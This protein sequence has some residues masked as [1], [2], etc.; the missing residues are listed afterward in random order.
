LTSEAPPTEALLAPRQ[1][2]SLAVESAEEIEAR[3]STL[4]ARPGCYIFRDKNGE[5]LYVGKAK[6]LRSRVRSYFQSSSS[7]DRAFL[8]FLRGYA[9]EL[10]TIV[11]DTEKEAAILE[12]SLIKEQHPR[13]NVKLRDD[14]E[15]LTLRLDQRQTWPRLDLVRRPEPDGARYYGPYHSATAARRTLKLVEKHFQLRTCSDRE[16]DTRT[17]PCLQYQIKRC[18]GPCVYEVDRD[19]YG[20]QVRSVGLFLEGRHDELT[21]QLGARMQEAS[22]DLRFELAAIYRDQM[23]AIESVRQHQRVVAVTDK[24]QDVV[25]IYR[26]GDLIEISVLYVR[27]G[28][29]I[30]AVSFSP[31]RVE[32]PDQEVVAGYIREHYSDDGVGAA[33]PDEIILPLLPEGVE[34]ISEWLS[35]AGMT[36]RTRGKANEGHERVSLRKVQLLA[37]ERGP[38]KQLLELALDNARHA[39]DEKRRAEQDIFERLGRMQAKLRLPTLPRYIEC[40]DI[41]HLGGQD[42]Y[43]SIV[44][45]RDGAPSKADYRSYKVRTPVEGDDYA[46]MYEVLSR[47]FIRGRQA[48]AGEAWALPDLLVVDGGRGQLAVALTAAHDLGL[49]DLP[50]CG[51]AKERETVTGERMVDRVYLPGQKNPISLKPNTPELFLLALARDEAHRFANRSRAR[52]GK[53]R[54]FTSGLD[55]VPGIGP[56]TRQLLMRHIG[57]LEQVRGASDDALLAIRGVDRRHV[58]ALRSYFAAAAP[59]EVPMS[60]DEG[61]GESDL[62]ELESLDAGAESTVAGELEASGLMPET[63]GEPDDPEPSSAPSSPSHL[64]PESALEPSAPIAPAQVGAVRQA[65]DH[66]V[67]ETAPEGGEGV[68]SETPSP[69]LQPGPEA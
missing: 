7:D 60:D 41:S 34:G 25:G 22:E 42:T 43:G 59:E 35:E 10:E 55:Q 68:G 67:P 65:A 27:A 23:R 53:Q 66:A 28:R 46:A 1:R 44:A 13:F 19:L 48:E 17:R 69:E 64:E 20:E 29:V 56:K 63:S 11:T 24:D 15:F 31:P 61:E 45:L 52:A 14:K 6:S 40:I 5:S 12:N 38:R 57:G 51:L 26:E 58:K 2:Q 32:I 9:A 54:R 8:P 49:H 37:P 18:P 50:V 33:I 21:R 4:P 30:E 62:G 16:L 3:L 39:F 47:R 36:R